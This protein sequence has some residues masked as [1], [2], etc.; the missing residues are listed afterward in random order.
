MARTTIL[1]AALLIALGVGAY[2][3]TGMQSWTA[4]IPS[5]A[6]ALLGICGVIALDP[7]KRK[8][9][10]HAAV[11]LAVLGCAGGAPGVIKALKW[12]TS[13]SEPVRPAAVV[14]QAVM[15]AVL[16]PYIVLCVKSFIDARRAKPTA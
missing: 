2:F 9:A 3:V 4:L 12:V 1:F 6:G 14:V 15:S 16:L 5:I 7:N 13:G 8:H 10:M 11:L